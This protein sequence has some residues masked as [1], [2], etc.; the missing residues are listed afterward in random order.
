MVNIKWIKYDDDNQP[1][2]GQFVLVYFPGAAVSHKLDVRYFR[3]KKPGYCWGWYPGGS[4]PNG[5]YWVAINDVPVP[6]DDV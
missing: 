4:N 6:G 2:D 3:P 1:K 5:T